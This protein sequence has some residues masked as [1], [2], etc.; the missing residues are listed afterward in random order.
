MAVF[1]PV[2][3]FACS[4]MPVMVMLIMLSASCA[5]SN[6]EVINTGKDIPAVDNNPAISYQP[7]APFS[8]HEERYRQLVMALTEHGIA[9]ERIREIF[10]SAKAKQKDTTAI[11]RL[12]VKRSGIASLKSQVQLDDISAQINRHIDRNNKSYAALEQR[13]GVNREI[14]AAILFKETQLG[15]F[16]NWQHDSFV[17]FN[18]ILSFL[19]FSSGDSEHQKKRIARL[20]TIARQSLQ[21]LLRYCETNN[22]DIVKTSF[23]S[24]FAG[25]IGIPQFLPLYLDYAVSAGDTRPDLNKTGDA[26]LSLGNLLQHKFNWPGLMQLE[27]LQ[28][29]DEI[30]RRYVSYDKKTTDA[31]FCMSVDQE[32][33]PLRNFAAENADI[34]AIDYISR[35]GSVLMQ[36]NFSS[37]YVLDVLQLAFQTH[38]LRVPK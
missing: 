16:S 1:R 9:P 7:I 5:S 21:A 25:A 38:R 4:K 3:D 22:I 10:S 37:Y 18:N 33:F 15:Q 28:S 6:E 32:G 35:Y 2:D 12:S 11:E 23:P 24:S 29:I 13:F 20:V 26:I 8:R 31:S 36:Y 30:Y 17:V 14:A 34:A 19:E 27:R